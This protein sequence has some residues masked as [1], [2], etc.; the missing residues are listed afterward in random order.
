MLIYAVIRETLKNQRLT[1]QHVEI[2]GV[3]LKTVFEKKGAKRTH[4]KRPEE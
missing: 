3:A 4:T 1:L 2:I